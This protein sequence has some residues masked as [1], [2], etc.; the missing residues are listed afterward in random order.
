M[1]DDF[2]VL[3]TYKGTDLV[4]TNYERLMPFAEV[5]GKCFE[6]VADSYVT[7][8]DGTGIVHIAPAYGDD[9]N[10][11]C[12]ENGIGFVNPVGKDGC[13]TTGPWKGTLV[14][15]KDLEIEIIKWLKE[16]DKLFKKIKL[17]HDYPHCWRCHSPLIY[18]SKPAWYIRT[19]E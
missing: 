6:V 2:E 14:T 18:Y 10:R 15:D 4:G 16:N 9:D 19:T 17:T 7:S 1:G 3:E 12:K 13:Y 11:V 8:E 5:E